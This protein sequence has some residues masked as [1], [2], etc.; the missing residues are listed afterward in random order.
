MHRT[1]TSP[2]LLARA[3]AFLAGLLCVFPAAAN[4]L[5]P[6]LVHGSFGLNQPNGLTLE[7]TNSPGTIINWE[8]F[9]IGVGE[10]TRFLQQNAASG[11]LNRVTGAQL[12]ELM[13]TL[14][15]NGRVF[16][17]NGNGIVV[18]ENAIIDTAGLVMSTLDIHDADFIAGRLK[19]EGD[20]TSGSIR[21]MGYI[22]TAPGGEVILLAPRIVNEAVDGVENSGL[23]ENEGGELILAAGY[24]IT[25]TS[26]DDPDITFEVQAPENEVINLGQLIARGGTVELL[27][28][29]IRH[30]G[31][32]NADALHVD[33]Q[34]RVSLIAS[35]HIET[36]ADSVITAN[37]DLGGEAGQVTVHARAVDETSTTSVALSGEIHADG[38]RGGTLHVLAGEVDVTAATLTANGTAQGGEIRVGGDVQ[39]GDSLAAAT[40]TNVDAASSLSA[41]AVED[42]DGGS[43]VVWSEERTEFRG[44]ASARGGLHGGDGG[45]LEVSGKEVLTLRGSLDVGAPAGSSGTVLL[46][47]KNVFVT[48][49]EDSGTKF[50]NPN[51]GAGDRFSSSFSVLPNGNI[52]VRNQN[53]DVG[54]LI[55]AG[56]ILLFDPAGDLL[57]VLSGNAAGERLGS[58]FHSTVADGN[59]VFRSPNA[60]AAQQGAVILFNDDLGV[61][62]GRVS[63]AS[64]NEQLGLNVDFFGPPNSYVI[65]SNLADVG[66]M[67]D[68]GAVILV[69]AFTGLEIGRLSGTAAGDMAGSSSIIMRGSGNYLV[70]VPNANIGGIVDAGSVFLASGTSGGLIGRINGNNTNEFLGNNVNTFSFG[71]NDFAVIST[72][73]NN[74]A[75]TNAGAFI[76]GADVNLGGGNIER[77]R[78]MGSSTNEL[79]GGSS[80]QILSSG[81]YV[82]FSPGADVGGMVDAGS[83]VLADRATGNALGRVSGA[84]AGDAVGTST[85]GSILFVQ[86]S[87]TGNYWIQAPKADPGGLVDAGTLFL[88]NGMTGNAI[89]QFNGDT[90][91]EFFSS[92]LESSFS[93]GFDKRIV[94]SQGHGGNAGFVG[95]FDSIDLGGGSFLVGSVQGVT[96]GDLVGNRSNTFLS[97]GNYLVGA[98][99][100][101]NGSTLNAGSVF[102][103]DNA[104]GSSILQVQGDTLNEM[105]GD[106]G[107]VDTFT[108][109]SFD[110]FLIISKEN[111]GNRGS[112]FFVNGS[113]TPSL[114]GTLTGLRANDMLGS[115]TDGFGSNAIR[116]VAGGFLVPVPNADPGAGVPIVDA[117][118][119]FLVDGTGAS[120]APAINGV[121]ANDRLGENIDFFTLG[122][123][124]ILLKIPNSDAGGLD[125]GQIQSVDT[126]TLTAN[127][128]INGNAGEGLGGGF[129][130]PQFLSSGDFVIFSPGDDT[131]AT[132]AGRLLL[133]DPTTGT[134][135]GSAFGQTLNE[136]FGNFGFVFERSSG[137]F[138]APSTSASPGG[139]AN[140]GSVYLVDGTL[141]TTIGRIDGTAV[142]EFFGSSIDS[143]SAPGDDIFITSTRATVGGFANAGTVIQAAAVDL[144]GGNII[145][146]RVD[147]VGA[148]EFFGSFGS[149]NLGSGNFLFRSPNAAPGGRA[150]A[151]TITFYDAN[152]GSVLNRLTGATAGDAIGNNFPTTTSSGALFFR[153]V[154]VDVGGIVDAGEVLLVNP[155]GTVLGRASGNNTNERFGSLFSFLTSDEFLVRAPLHNNGAILGAGGIFRL[156]NTD[157]G[158]GN[159][160][161]GQIL[162]TSANEGLGTSF[163]SFF[164]TNA[165]IASP[166]ADVGGIVDAGSLIIFDPETFTEI[167]RINGTSANERLGAIG[168]TFIG[169]DVRLLRSPDADV[170]G[171]VGAGTAILIDTAAAVEL[172]RTNGVS[173]GERFGALFPTFFSGSYLFRSPDASPSGLLNAGRLVQVSSSSGHAVQIVNGIS[174][175]ERLGAFFPTF[176]SSG[177]LLFPSPDADVGGLVDAGRFVFFDPTAIAADP[178]TDFTFDNLPGADFTITA[179]ILESLLNAGT[180]LILQANNDISFG[181]GAHLSATAG[182]LVLQAGRSIM[183]ESMLNVPTLSL[184]ANET[185]AIVPAFRDAG[186]GDVTVSN[187]SLASNNLTISGEN[188]YFQDATVTADN[189]TL[190]A[191]NEI[192]IDPSALAIERLVSDSMY[193]TVEGSTVVA[194]VATIDAYHVNI[195]GTET[196]AAYVLA[197]S[198]LDIS[199]DSV[200][201]MAGSGT[202]AFAALVSLNALNLDVGSLDL[203][204]GSGAGAPLPLGS[205]AFTT[206]NA[207]GGALPPVAMVFAFQEL[208]LTADHVHLTGGSGDNTFA[209]LVS[210][211]LFNVTAETATLTPGSGVNADAVFLALGGLADIGIPNC[212]G[213]DQLF[214]DPLFDPAAQSGVYI[215]GL[216][217]DPSI[218]AILAMLDTDTGDLDD[219]DAEEEEEDGPGECN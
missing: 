77:G 44:Y 79:L 37:N 201:I 74:G 199:A 68:A 34:G 133:V 81:D 111:G 131:V 11:V 138:F 211:G 142:S 92:I 123:G 148:G 134:V 6:T 102:V 149:Q 16:L 49:P 170:A 52:L 183:I 32:I 71:A 191:T 28:G 50:V 80:F 120:L 215:A 119:L 57:G 61:E 165:A 145:R 126:A 130:S 135:R 87:T 1:I 7:I 51:P 136:G 177:D 48:A 89:G 210:T 18:G 53:A 171:M 182:S 86:E 75:S 118:S 100:M 15:S 9:N 42:G 91:G 26:L 63:G 139:V 20:E 116:T 212:T 173:A 33:D 30:S 23:I 137:N 179:D 188:I 19:F 56:E 101:A 164:T 146:G 54:G 106:F 115:G 214:G 144:G 88:A 104:T 132:D 168:L 58:L 193:F 143:F 27:A 98:P 150:G 4:P 46:D 94:R 213:C 65:R 66:G 159:I 157:L 3:G 110:N 154:S 195:K 55:D 47:P 105:L 207:T 45:F 12:S 192:F 39:G 21:N 208:N 198:L 124:D 117:G 181:M 24:A 2:R 189:G 156:T 40:K 13:G 62:I 109:G 162:G 167:N 141:G 190:M 186:P 114:L 64:A 147:G 73:H 83:V 155:T 93:I 70:R 125:S 17:I 72:L 99:N 140:A 60:N 185:G 96:G 31:E 67:V 169:T 151:G 200:D 82:I 206:F 38:E 184:L 85:F 216:L 174:A 41:D 69:D 43:V 178:T 107:N 103:V 176:L 112:I 194:D 152:T 172:G 209:A 95:L 35:N 25:I 78:V 160:I 219:D 203:R 121:F 202:N 204:G 217:Q 108:L 97:N 196:H 113:D 76:L 129:S 90:A 163:P 8:A 84:A 29:T 22:K 158:G 197:N 128:T 5:N 127:W 166:N 180:S 59:L 218:E 122:F 10:T 36:T 175:G 14:S 187:T 161:E 205:E 153:N